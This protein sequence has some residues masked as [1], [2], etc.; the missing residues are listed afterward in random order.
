MSTSGLF[1]S[2]LQKFVSGGLEGIFSKR[3]PPHMATFPLVLPRPRYLVAGARN[4]LSLL[5]TGWLCVEGCCICSPADCPRD[6]SFA[7]VYLINAHSDKRMSCIED[8]LET[9]FPLNPSSPLPSHHSMTVQGVVGGK[10]P[11]ESSGLPPLV[12]S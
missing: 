3:K 6:Q 11:H 4:G 1:C 9:G 12:W 7:L 10:S 2:R 8:G 5:M